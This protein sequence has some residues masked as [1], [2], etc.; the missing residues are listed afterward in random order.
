MP[1]IQRY[2]I[3]IAPSMVLFFVMEIYSKS[4]VDCRNTAITYNMIKENV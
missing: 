4:K 2:L 3:N 1:I